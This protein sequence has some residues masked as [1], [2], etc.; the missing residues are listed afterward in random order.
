MRGFGIFEYIKVVIAF[1][2]CEDVFIL[3][4]VYVYDSSTHFYFRC[5]KRVFRI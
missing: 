2:I 4:T 3:I 5:I 1:S